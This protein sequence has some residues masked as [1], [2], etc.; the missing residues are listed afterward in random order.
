MP[1]FGSQTNKRNHASFRKLNCFLISYDT[2]VLVHK[3]RRSFSWGSFTRCHLVVTSCSKN[4][5]WTTCIFQVEDCVH[6]I[7]FL[8]RE[9]WRQMC[10]SFSWQ[11]KKEKFKKASKMASI[12]CRELSDKTYS[13][14][15]TCSINLKNLHAG[16]T[17][18][19]R[20]TYL[21]S[22]LFYDL[23]LYGP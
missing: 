6:T 2:S 14:G 11:G 9:F 10:T 1:H 4:L 22:H 19:L 13:H 12:D 18:F 3:K 16:T 5:Y 17:L 21:R 8:S 7:R 15:V 23:G 20:L